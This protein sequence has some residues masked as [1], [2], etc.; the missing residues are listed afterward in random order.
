[1]ALDSRSSTAG[2]FVVTVDGTAVSFLKKFEGFHP[3]ADV[4]ANDMGPQLFQSKHVANFKW[5]PGKFTV[6]AGM[7][8]GMWNWIKAA[9]EKGY[10]RKNGSVVSGDFDYNARTELAWQDGL[11]TSVNFPKLDASGKDAV[12]LDVEVEAEQVRWSK[13]D[14]KISAQY[15]TKQKAWLAP[16]FRFSLGNLP[17]ERVSTIDAFT[18]KCSVATDHTGIHREHAKVPAKVTTPDIKFE[19]SAADAGPW[20]DAARKWFV[21]G[22]HLENHHMQGRI[23]LLGPDMKQVMAAIELHNCGFKSFKTGALE[24]NSEKVHRIAV[25]IYLE[26]LTFSEYDGDA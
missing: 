20:S 2:R 10:V 23:E 13:A 22:Q 18:W 4:V 24:A 17:C 8:R 16:N 11:I 12:Y 5:T 14:G 15:G 1:M 21:D 7:G 25:E 26:G 19:V 3:E 9:F 6:G